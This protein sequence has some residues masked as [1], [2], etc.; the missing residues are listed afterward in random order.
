MAITKL[1]SLQVLQNEFKPFQICVM[2]SQTE[3][4]HI[5]LTDDREKQLVLQSCSHHPTSLCSQTVRTQKHACF[6][7]NTI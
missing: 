5:S 2:S 6:H 3:C 7:H 4:E 1:Q